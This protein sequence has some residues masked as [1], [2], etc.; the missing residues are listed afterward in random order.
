VKARTMLRPV[1]LGAVLFALV[2]ALFGCAARG[3][4]QTK[5]KQT[6]V[7]SQVREAIVRDHPG[8]AFLPGRL[9][10]GY[11]YANWENC[12]NQS[13]Y[14]LNFRHGSGTSQVSIALQVQRRPC[15]ALPKSPAKDTHT[16]HVNGHTL[17]WLQSENG[18]IVWRCIANRERSFVIFGVTSS[19]P[20]RE[21]AELVGYA[22]PAH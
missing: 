15:P 14:E 18:P 22:L 4:N 6:T 3:S 17:K 12:R 20:R 16:L 7:P 13:C 1:V 9:P 21:L 5:S 19:A 2:L 8:M 11:R 10:S